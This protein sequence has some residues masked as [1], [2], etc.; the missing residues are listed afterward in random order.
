MTDMEEGLLLDCRSSSVYYDWLSMAGGIELI[1]KVG[2][3]V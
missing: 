2:G 1:C 3:M